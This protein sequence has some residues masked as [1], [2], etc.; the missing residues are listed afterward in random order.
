MASNILH[1]H[2][3]AIAHAPCIPVTKSH[4]VSNIYT[5]GE[6]NQTSGLNCREQQSYQVW[7]NNFP[8]NLALTAWIYNVSFPGGI[9]RITNFDGS[10]KI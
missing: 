1:N 6:Q 2:L 8:G 5:W 10:W 7:L 4:L 9:D 3:S